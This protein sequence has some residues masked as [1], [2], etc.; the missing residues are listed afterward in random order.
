MKTI[1]SLLLILLFSLTASAARNKYF[2]EDTYFFGGLGGVTKEELSYLMGLDSNA[3][4]QLDGKVNNT[5]NE[6]ISGVKTFTGKI[7]ASSTTNGS[8]PCPVMTDAEITALASPSEGDCAFN[9]T[10]NNL[11]T[12]DGVS[13]NEA[14]G[15]GGISNWATSESY[16]IDDVVIESGKIY[17]CLADHTSGTF[18]TDLAG[19]NWVEI[20][21][22]LSIKS[23]NASA[24]SVKSLITGYNQL[25][26]TGTGEAYLESPGNLLSNPSFNA[27]VVANA[28][29]GWTVTATGTATCTISISTSSPMDGEKQYLLMEAVGGASGGTCSIK[30][31]ATTSRATNAVVGFSYRSDPLGACPGGHPTIEVR[32]LVNGS[33][34]TTQDATECSTSAAW[35]GFYINEVTGSTS[36]GVEAVVTVP[37]STSTDIAVDAAKVS[38]GELPLIKGMSFIGSATYKVSNC[39][40]ATTSTGN[41]PVD[42]DCVPTTEGLVSAPSTRIPGVTVNNAPAGT[43]F[44]VAEVA[45]WANAA[46][47]VYP[48]VSDGTTSGPAQFL[49]F[50]EN[51]NIGIFSPSFTYSNSGSRTWQMAIGSNASS[52]TVNIY[53]DNTL[54][55]YTKFSVYYVPPGSYETIGADCGKNCE[56][57][58]SA[59]VTDGSGTTSVTEERPS[60][61]W[62]NGNC[63]NPSSGTYQCVSD[64]NIFSANARCW[65]EPT[66]SATRLTRVNTSYS[67]GVLTIDVTTVAD[68]GAGAD[69]SFF[70]FC[71][72]D[73]TSRILQGHVADY[74]RMPG[75]ATRKPVLFG[76][77]W[78][79]AALLANSDG[80]STAGSDAGS[81]NYN[82]TLSGLQD[83][84]EW[85]N[86]H[87]LTGGSTV[88]C[89]YNKGSS[90]STLLKVYCHNSATSSTPLSS[91]QFFFSCKGYTQ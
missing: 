31:E 34:V 87:A 55:R 48:Y 37:A 28:T 25:T 60:T 64:A 23:H 86:V 5:G 41:F 46:G 47:D 6:S 85:C 68:T 88:T 79:S 42:A 17:Q 84:P 22:T 90:T 78:N 76:G 29:T 15:A 89:Y 80:I 16:L 11:M 9:S 18:S 19:G 24:Q 73:R 27:P 2:D 4:T 44:I 65:V 3:Q 40:W 82:I 21:N 91:R 70:L 63:T 39:A 33:T 66:V 32:T 12:Y 81:G 8:Q 53:G 30:Q 56:P 61:G 57:I 20:S 67:S 10:L 71:Q 72:N 38:P 1:L 59:L 49:N 69:T 14:G 54:G 7:V 13:W 52:A 75:T 62:V 83:T 77:Y 35:E 51:R 43:Y 45:L 26:E 36:T 58:L 50:N 74:A